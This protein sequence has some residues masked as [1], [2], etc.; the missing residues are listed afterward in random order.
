MKKPS[1][2]QVVVGIQITAA[3]A[4]VSLVSIGAGM[5]YRPAGLIVP[6]LLLG[7]FGLL[8]DLRRRR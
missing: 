6:G 2:A 3:I 7:T 4:G 1:L 5:V 8:F